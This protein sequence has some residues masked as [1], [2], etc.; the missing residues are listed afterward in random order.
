[1]LTLNGL[2]PP[3]ICGLDFDNQMAFGIWASGLQ[4]MQIASGES[5]GE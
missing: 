4:P 5:G 1:M 2:K 3:N